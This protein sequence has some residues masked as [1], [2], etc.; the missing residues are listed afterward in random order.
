MSDLLNNGYYEI[1]IIE[2]HKGETLKMT[3][4]GDGIEDWIR[5]FKKVLFWV[6]FHPN[7]I[8]EAFLEEE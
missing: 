8:K 1:T 6:E 5:L 7:T 3:L 4:L 2:P